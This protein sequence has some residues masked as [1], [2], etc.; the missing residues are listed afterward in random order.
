MAR[1]PGGKFKG[2]T[3]QGVRPAE[4]FPAPRT[5]NEAQRDDPFSSAAFFG[6]PGQD[7]VDDRAR[8]ALSASARADTS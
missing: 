5:S 1:K 3:G 8:S 2:E 4:F 6:P 7:K